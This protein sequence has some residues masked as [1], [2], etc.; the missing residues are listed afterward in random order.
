MRHMHHIVCLCCKHLHCH[1]AQTFVPVDAAVH[2]PFSIYNSSACHKDL[3]TVFCSRRGLCKSTGEG[4]ISVK[5][6]AEESHAIA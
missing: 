4:Q 1:Q 6:K 2:M 3:K 5:D